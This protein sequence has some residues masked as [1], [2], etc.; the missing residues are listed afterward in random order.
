MKSFLKK[1]VSLFNTGNGKFDFNNIIQR[2]SLVFLFL[3]SQ[4]EVHTKLH[5][6]RKNFKYLAIL[7][8]T[9]KKLLSCLTLPFNLSKFNI[10]CKNTFFKFRTKFV[11]F[12]YFQAGTQKIYCTVIFY[13][14]TFK[15]FQT[16]NFVQKQNSL[17]LGP[18]LP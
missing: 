17:S 4:I 16:Q 7:G 8:Q 12:E 1:A 18:K 14:S 15:F 13:I 5:V 2:C 3:S 11:L 10:S 9:Q 6:G